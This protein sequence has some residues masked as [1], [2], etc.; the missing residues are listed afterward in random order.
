MLTLYLTVNILIESGSYLQEAFCCIELFG[1]GG[2]VGGGGGGG[3][4][5]ACM[6]VLL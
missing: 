1:K 4:V 2:Y 3:G 5:C 6:Y